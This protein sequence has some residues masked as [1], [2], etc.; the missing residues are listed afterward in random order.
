MRD[1]QFISELMMLQLNG[2]IFGF[3]QDLLD[4]V[5]A[6]YDV[7]TEADPNFSEEGFI[8]RFQEF[9]E[10]ILGLEAVAGVVTEFAKSA[11]NFFSLWA[12][13]A[14]QYEHLPPAEE[15]AERYRVFMTQVLTLLKTDDAEQF[16]ELA[17]QDPYP[18]AY[19][20]NARG[21]N[22]EFPQRFERHRALV[23]AVLGID[24]PADEDD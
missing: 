1:V 20:Q 12:L 21:A 10:R 6:E 18:F 11:T 4:S 13:V 8:E 22:T 5:Y 23:R 2:R 14:L 16:A 24:I 7:P 15:L 9:K 3:S 19:A 17:E